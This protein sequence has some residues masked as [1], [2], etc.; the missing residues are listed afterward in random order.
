MTNVYC[1]MGYPGS[2]KSTASS[3]ASDAGL[4]VVVM[5][6]VVRERARADMGDDADSD[7]IGVWATGYRERNGNDIFA[8]HTAETVEETDAETVVIDGMRTPTELAVF[9]KRFDA[10]TV[11]YV[12]TSFE[13]RLE[14]LQMRG[15]DGEDTFTRA[16]LKR[17]DTREDDWGVGALVDDEHYDVTLDNE[18]SFEEFEERVVEV[19]SAA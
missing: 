2:G 8:V 11:V 12:D 16:D 6:D 15:R 17:R 9:R 4:P 10:V 7:D 18:G 5:G 13:T 14:R 19:L 3:I 1:F